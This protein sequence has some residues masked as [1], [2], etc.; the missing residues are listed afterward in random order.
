MSRITDRTKAL[1]ILK[2]I[3]EK[4]NIYSVIHYSSESFVDLAGK[5]PRITSIA[6]QNL[7]SGQAELF[8]IY[9]TAEIMKIKEENILENYSKIEK[10]MLSDF[11]GFV[12][13]NNSRMWL[14]WNMRDSIY[15]FQALEHRFQVLKGKPFKLP[16]TQKLSIADLFKDLYGPNYIENPKMTKLMDKNFLKPLN[17]L[18]GSEEAQAFKDNKYHNLSMSTAGKVRMFSQM[19]D[20]A[21]DDTLKTNTKKIELYGIG[22][23]AKWHYFKETKWFLTVSWLT[24]TII[25]TL[26]GYFLPKFFGG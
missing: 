13:T 8:A 24:T 18:S 2:E 9:K 12:E 6:I 5:S 19:V 20:L 14:H 7:E 10:N 15:G 3:D 25:G 17:F 1:K 22:L 4:K 23:E 11:F 26:I 16:N 21:I